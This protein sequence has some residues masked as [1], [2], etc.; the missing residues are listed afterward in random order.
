M[1]SLLS[2]LTPHLSQKRHLTHRVLDAIISKTVSHTLGAG[3][4]CIDDKLSAIEG[5]KVVGIFLSQ[6]IIQERNG[7]FET[8]VI[9][10]GWLPPLHASMVR[11]RRHSP[12]WSQV[13]SSPSNIPLLSD[14]FQVGFPGEL[15]DR[16]LGAGSLLEHILRIDTCRSEGS[17]TGEGED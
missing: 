1:D 7:S 15:G 8:W 17:G 14:L 10:R 12:P 6:S 13:R 11:E 16:D 2:I 5:G 4:S 9:S 3:I